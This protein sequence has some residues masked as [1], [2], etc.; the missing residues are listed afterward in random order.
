MCTM[1][2]QKQKMQAL[3]SL[4]THT[5]IHTH[6]VTRTHN[7]KYN[8][9]CVCCMLY[10]YCMCHNS[11][12]YILCLSVQYLQK[13]TY[14]KMYRMEE[15]NGV[16]L[17]RN[18]QRNECREGDL[19]PMSSIYYLGVFRVRHTVGQAA[20]S[21]GQNCVTIFFSRSAKLFS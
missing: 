3:F 20:S 8:S 5:Q 21:S 13:P 11:F 6:T 14:Y 16:E 1:D 7:S 18:A 19:C 2:T 10:V 12:L 17:S 9:T 4:H 15:S